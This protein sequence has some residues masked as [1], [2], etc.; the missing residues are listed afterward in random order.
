MEEA[1]DGGSNA[2]SAEGGRLDE[3]EEHAGE[4]NCADGRLMT[5]T[6]MMGTSGLTAVVMVTFLTNLSFLESKISNQGEK[7]GQ[8]EYKKM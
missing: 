8:R 6:M 3:T 1:G 2:V 4:T 5:M 7:D